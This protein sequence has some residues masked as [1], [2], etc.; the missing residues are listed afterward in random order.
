[1]PDRR[2]KRANIPGVAWI[3]GAVLSLP[4]LAGL[5]G[6]VLPA[7]GYLPALGSNAI[8]LDA[9]RDLWAWPGLMP[10]VMLSLRVGLISTVISL[11]V[12]VLIC[13]SLHRTRLFQAM[14]AQLSVLL[15]VP[16][17]AAA[18]GLAF[19][20]APSGWIAR[21]LSPW[22][23]GWD[24]PPDLLI[25]NDP[26][27]VALILGLV[28]KEVP[29]LMLMTLAALGQVRVSQAEATA[30]ALGYTP[31][32]A[33]IKTTLPLVYRQIRLPIYAVLAF[34][35]SVVDMAVILAPNT[36]PPLAV[37][38][39]DW[40][41]D[42]DLALRFQA[43]AGATLQLALVALALVIWRFG[44][45]AVG[46]L[47]RRWVA[48]GGRGGPRVE[49]AL[50]IGASAALVLSCGS[51]LFG[52]LGLAVWSFA[53]LWPFPDTLPD[54]MTLRSWTRVSSRLGEPMAET[55]LIAGAATGLALILT[56]ASLEVEHRNRLSPGN[57]ALW[58]LYLPLLVPQ[59]SFLSGLQTFSLTLGLD[60]NRMAVILSHLVF[61]LPYVFL[62]M[63][64]PW[65]AWDARYGTVAHALGA[66]PARV[67]WR[68]RLPMLLA[69]VLIASAV[70]LS[71][72][73]GQYLP[74]LLIGGG[75]VET[76]TTEAI[77]L[78]S[79]GDRR[80]IGIYALT[81]TAVALTPFAFAV[82]VPRMVQRRRR[83]RGH[84]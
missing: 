51:I 35:L 31:T 9:F 61:V 63:S 21:A 62:T 27:G 53:G 4:V 42:P 8:G 52:V 29:F 38:V 70:G 50:R 15:S 22:L 45:S 11:A 84:G 34:S 5:F 60:G 56:L 23:T 67:L 71:V 46:T 43:S 66:S 14:L 79:G 74:T 37:Q 77:A 7:F 18:F 19:L 81:L 3:A 10:S 54:Q 49:T 64:G 1:M 25:V 75:R 57:G 82:L 36:P 41:N 28:I 2:A 47:G 24:R 6:T 26:Q 83:R 80:I 44:E 65:R 73:V 40:M 30:R 17:A 39:V 33:W 58:V 72:S 69:P 59:I 78:A 16:H 13:A 76:L 20:I 12:V 68:V 55:L 48:A 32:L